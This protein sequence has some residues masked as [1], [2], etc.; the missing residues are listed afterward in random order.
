MPTPCPGRFAKSFS[1]IVFL[2]LVILVANELAVP[3]H[4]VRPVEARR[5]TGKPNIIF[6]LADDLGYGDLG[7]FGQ[8]LIKTPFLDQTAAQGMRFTDC[9]V[10]SPVCAPSRCSLL[11]GRHS[12]HCYIRGMANPD[13][14]LRPEDVTVAEVLK[15]AG[16]TTGTIGKW[17]LG[18]AGST[19]SPNRKGFDYAFGFLDH[20]EG[21]YF[22]HTLWRNEEIVQVPQGSYQQELF[23]QDALDFISREKDNPFF[24]YLA[25]MAPHSPYEV[26]SDQPYSNET[27]SQGDKSFAAL[28]TRLDRDV[29]RITSLLK[30]LGI[31]DNTIVFFSSDNGPE[32]DNM[33]HSAGPLSS[34]KRMLGEGGIR[35]PLI[36]CWP[37]NIPA[38]QVNRVP[39]G[40]WDFMTT[41]ADLAGAN[42]PSDTDGTPMLPALF[43]ADITHPP[44]YW[45]FHI[46]NCKGFMF[47]VRMGKWKMLRTDY[48]RRKRLKFRTIELYDLD[49]DLSEQVNVAD[50]HPDIVEQLARILEREHTESDL[51]PS[52]PENCGR[53]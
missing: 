43:G 9:Y 22:P 41:A 42:V 31:D 34:H 40:L 48:W 49:A 33:F 15:R 27:W 45:E 26:P 6:V 4:I 7:C 23:T 18:D 8:K 35:V 10:G 25:Y 3:D 5:T 13:R 37:G 12:G 50:Q 32:G 11:T 44:L 21:D 47:A 36:A 29:G 28:V 20:S 24:L 46:K 52:L 1:V 30:E 51:F 19:G 53:Q 39:C 16:Y 17:G 14:P 2:G 38:G